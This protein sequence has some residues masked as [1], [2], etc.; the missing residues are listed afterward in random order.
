MACGGVFRVGLSWEMICIN[1]F[2]AVRATLSQ[3]LLVLLQYRP[4][5]LRSR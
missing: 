2:A 4:E 3:L 5:P 1:G